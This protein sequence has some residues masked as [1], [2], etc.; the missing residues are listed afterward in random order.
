MTYDSELA[1]LEL[2]HLRYC[3]AVAEELNFTRAARKLNIAQPPLSQQIKQ[4]EERLGVALFVRSS[5]KCELTPAG[6]AFV[7]AARRALAEVGRGA[8]AAKRAG[9]GET[10]RLRVGFTDSAALSVLPALVRRFRAAH[11][12]VHLELREASTNA[13]LL[14]LERDQEDIILVR[15]PLR[16]QAVTVEVLLRERFMAAVPDDWPLSHRRSLSLP[17]I[18]AEPLVLFQRH[19]APEFHDSI[20]GMFRRAKCTPH[21]AYEAAEYQTM[22]SL[23]AAGLGI[24]IVPASVRNLGRVGVRYLPLAGARERAEVVIA[25]RDKTASQS[26]RAFAKL[27]RAMRRDPSRYRPP[28]RDLAGTTCLR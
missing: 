6:V 11:P 23:V 10:D 28:D 27:A 4:V 19:L 21:I 15:G 26:V 13:Q 18:A 16:D 5:R 12:T 9:R 3:L 20:V 24:S 25:Y 1:H 14:A 2:R 7:E 22:M 8:E 17:V